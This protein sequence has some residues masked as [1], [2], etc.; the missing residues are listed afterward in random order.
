MCF[1]TQNGSVGGS[2][3]EADVDGGPTKLISPVI[4]LDGT[5]GIISYARWFF[6]SSTGDS[7]VTEISND[8]GVSWEF[9][10]ETSGTNS[11]WELISFRVGD[12]VIP[13]AEVRIR[14]V[15]NDGAPASVVEAG[16]DNLQLD[17][18]SCDVDEPCLG[19][20]DGGGVVNVDDLLFI[21]AAFG[22]QTDGAADLDD[23]GFVTVNDV[24]VVIGA[25]GAC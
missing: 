11:T 6:D 7:L 20:I 9:V 16:I 5:D 8:G 3:G 25:W 12:F 10:Q 21:L 2:S 18:Y 14:F 15:A 1:I 19:D 17:I 4:D 24:L 22:D 23:D 13:S